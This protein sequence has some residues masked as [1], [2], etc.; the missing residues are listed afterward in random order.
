MKKSLIDKKI[1]L[2]RATAG[3]PSPA[4]DYIEERLDLN[5]HLIKNKETSFFV[6]V[7]GNS[8]INSGISHND[9]LIVDRSL[10]PVRESIILAS[11]NGELVIKRLMK[12][13]SKNY[14]LKSENNSYP[15]IKINSST[16]ATIWGVVTYAIHSL[17]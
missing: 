10:I 11:I 3:F 17:T 8:M 2:I 9:I 16:D 4:E 12:D 7:S 13:Q 6:R 15:N 14:Y 1:R 5:N